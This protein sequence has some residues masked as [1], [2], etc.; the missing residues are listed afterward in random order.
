MQV[1]IKYNMFLLFNL[2]DVNLLTVLISGFDSNVLYNFFPSHF[3]Y[4]KYALSKNG[5]KIIHLK[6]KSCHQSSS[7]KLFYLICRPTKKP[8]EFQ[9]WESILLTDHHFSTYLL[10]KLEHVS[11][12]FPNHLIDR[13]FVMNKW[14]MVMHII[15]GIWLLYGLHLG[16][17]QMTR[18]D[19]LSQRLRIDI[20][21]FI[22]YHLAKCL[23]NTVYAKL[24]QACGDLKIS[25]I[26]CPREKKYT[27]GLGRKSYE[28]K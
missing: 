2:V 22:H 12:G 6:K 19:C 11:Y 16:F 28:L 20:F 27:V 3:F 13:D 1:L 23:W 15:M 5:I 21:L 4:N 7:S 10:S 17:N 24:M 25:Q 26:F 18:A 14:N 8:F 9:R